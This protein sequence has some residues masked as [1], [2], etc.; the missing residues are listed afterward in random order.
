MVGDGV[1][2]SPW[3]V[4]FAKSIDGADYCIGLGVVRER[5]LQAQ[6]HGHA[7]DGRI[8]GQEDI[9]EDDE[10]EE[11]AG[12]GDPPWLVAMLAV[13]PVEVCDGDGVY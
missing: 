3:A 4:N 9:V 12:F 8:D 11:G 6:N 7:G 13:I 10:G 1:A 2:K 5:V